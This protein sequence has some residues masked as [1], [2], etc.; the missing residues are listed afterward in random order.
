MDKKIFIA[1]H[2]GLVGSAL[3]RQLQ[4]KGYKN[5][6]LKTREEL[7][8]MNSEQVFRFF[9][10]E[11]P[12]WVFLAAAKVGGIYANNTYPVD[13]LL[14]NLKIQ[15]NIIEAS[16]KNNVEKLLFLGSSC[17]YPKLAPQPLKEEYLLTSALEPTNEPYAL[18]KI[19][20]IKLCSAFNKQYGTNY[21]SAMPCNLYGINDNYHAENAHVIPMLL[22]RFHEA[23]EKN[24]EKVTVWGTGTPMREFMCSD[25]LAEACV[26][27]MEN[28]NAKEIGEFINIGAGIDV[29]IRELAELIKETVGF[30][31]K[32]EFDTTKP[33]GTPKKLLDVSR[34]NAL[35]WKSKISLKEG[36]K[37]SYEDFL[38]NLCVRL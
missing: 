25:D 13:F 32:L 36:L 16:Y 30:E 37:I 18:A 4:K 38:N 5:F 26:Y 23:K 6:I 22:R 11:K 20:G 1:G 34:L 35:G 3:V 8:L 2:K 15:N 27:L 17:I 19:T 7:D 14:D 33:D 31:G 29:T 12:D 24:L 21:I 9:E 10:E 28:K